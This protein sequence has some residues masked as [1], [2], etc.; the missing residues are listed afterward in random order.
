M[1]W[2]HTVLNYTG[3]ERV[4]PLALYNFVILVTVLNDK[5]KRREEEEAELAVCEISTEIPFSKD[6]ATMHNIEFKLHC[7]FFFL[8]DYCLNI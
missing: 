8:S 1:K 2:P 6:N 7:V 4:S 5:I 3:I